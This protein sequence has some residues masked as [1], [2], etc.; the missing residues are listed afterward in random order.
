MTDTI[1]SRNP[2]D[3]DSL[4]GTLKTVLRKFLQDLDDCLPAVVLSYNRASNRAK[5]R[6]L[7]QTVLT[8]GERQPRPAVASVPVLRLGGGGFVV[9]FPIKSGDI[10]W[11]KAN[12][13]DLSLFKGD[14]TIP[15]SARK[16]SFSDALFVPDAFKE[17]VMFAEDA[18]CMVIQS[19][20]GT[21]R[22]AFGE[23]FLKATCPRFAIGDTEGYMP[24]QNAILDLQSTTKAFMPPRMTQ[25]QRDAIPSPAE[26]MIV[27]NIDTHALSSYNG[28]AWV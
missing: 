25:A 10:G 23:T 3:D 17:F 24:E 8:S 1:P 11:I 7:I 6:P 14:E 19:T 5:V 21:V 20:D 4:T 9:S 26:G 28:S 12:D 22:L 2:V 13:R 16:H 18:D 27:W 15:N